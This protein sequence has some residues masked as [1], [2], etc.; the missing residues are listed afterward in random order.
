MVSGGVEWPVPSPSPY[1]PAL[2]VLSQGGQE[3]PSAPWALVESASQRQPVILV[4][5]Y[6]QGGLFQFCHLTP[7]QVTLGTDYTKLS[8][9][10]PLLPLPPSDHP[11]SLPEAA[12][13]S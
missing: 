6:L 10:L 2:G 3:P 5:N 12:S 4:R 1:R 11:P 8:D 9:T 13:L 7:G